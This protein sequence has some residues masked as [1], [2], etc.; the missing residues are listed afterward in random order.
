MICFSLAKKDWTVTIG[1]DDDGEQSQFDGNSQD[2]GLRYGIA[3]VWDVKRPFYDEVDD[4][5]EHPMETE[6]DH[7]A[8][9]DID[10]NSESDLVSA[11]PEVDDGDDRE[12]TDDEIEGDVND[13]VTFINVPIEEDEANGEGGDANEEVL[14]EVRFFQIAGLVQ[15]IP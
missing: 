14:F 15:Y 3:D 11:A 2:D 8:D 4:A 9:G 12:E 5:H 1:I 7:G 6:N 10:N 13:D